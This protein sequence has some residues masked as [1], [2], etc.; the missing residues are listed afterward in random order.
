[1]AF[2]LIRDITAYESSDMGWY[3]FVKCSYCGTVFS[4]TEEGSCYCDADEDEYEYK[5]PSLPE[6]WDAILDIK[7]QDNHYEDLKEYIREVGFTQPV[8]VRK[9]KAGYFLI[10]GHH[11]IAVAIDLGISCIPVKVFPDEVPVYSC[12]ADDSGSWVRPTTGRTPDT[13]TT[14]N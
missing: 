4:E 6:I 11:R 7:R 10:D 5:E 13:F 1:M 12:L 2:A 8:R 9:M 14:Q 3:A